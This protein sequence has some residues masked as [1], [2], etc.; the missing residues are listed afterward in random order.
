MITGALRSTGTTAPLLGDDRLDG[1]PAAVLL[2]NVAPWWYVTPDR[3]AL[4]QA[5]PP[6]F[7][8]AFEQQRGHAPSARDLTAYLQMDAALGL[9]PE[10]AP[11]AT[12]P[13]TLYEALPGRYP[14]AARASSATSSVAAP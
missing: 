11:G 1:A 13:Y 4:L 3:A 7:A 8:E 12:P 2:G 14:G 9:R 5:T 10:A 6:A